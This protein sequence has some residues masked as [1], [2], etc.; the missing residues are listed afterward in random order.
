MEFQKELENRRET[1]FKNI[2]VVY[3][4]G[5]IKTN[6]QIHKANIF[7]TKLKELFISTHCKLKIKRIQTG[8]LKTKSQSK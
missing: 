6:Y 4:P 8:K 7:T 3:V 1:I 5:L 2:M